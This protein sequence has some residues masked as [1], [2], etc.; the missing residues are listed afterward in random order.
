[1]EIPNRQ[2]LGGR[3]VTQVCPLILARSVPVPKDAPTS[4]LG[5]TAGNTQMT[6]Q[7]L[8]EG[9]GT[10]ANL[11]LIPGIS[12]KLGD[13]RGM[14]L[15]LFLHYSMSYPWSLKRLSGRIDKR[16]PRGSALTLGR[17]SSY[18]HH[19][20]VKKLV[21][22]IDNSL[23]ETPCSTCQATK[24]SVLDGPLVESRGGLENILVCTTNKV[25]IRLQ[26]PKMITDLYMKNSRLPKD[27]NIYGNR[28]HVVGFCTNGTDPKVGSINRTEFNTPTGIIP[29]HK[30]CAKLVELTKVNSLDKGMLNSS[31]IHIISN[32]ELLILA[33]ESIK[34]KQGNMTGSPPRRRGCMGRPKDAPTPGLGITASNTQMTPQPLTE[35]PGTAAN[36]TLIPGISVK[37]GPQCSLYNG[38]GAGWGPE[39]GLGDRPV[40]QV[41]PPNPWPVGDWH[42]RMPMPIP[43]LA[44]A[45]PCIGQGFGDRHLQCLSDPK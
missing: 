6:P 15:I 17:N 39:Q 7:P 32:V 9:P 26:E 16:I 20:Y 37:L 14:L 3:P 34:S 18:D 28:A 45:N 1:M 4:G 11:T 33:Y 21:S 8:T 27:G 44:N 2:G 35:G 5:I 19:G 42:W 41:C 10:A 38:G 40:T 25:A 36:L 30:G 12:V 24:A 29:S 13:L 22:L 23:A 31:L 43:V